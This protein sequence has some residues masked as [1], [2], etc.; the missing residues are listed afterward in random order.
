MVNSISAT[1]YPKRWQNDLTCLALPY[2][3]LVVASIGVI[4]LTIVPAHSK[5]PG[6]AELL[7]DLTGL[8]YG[9]SVTD[10][11]GNVLVA[12][13]DEERFVPASNVKLFVT[14][15]ALAIEQEL[16][17][18]DTGLR[19]V[20]ELTDSGGTNIALV[21]RGDPTIG[22]GA[23][24]QIRC[25]ET[26]AEAVVEAGIT[27]VGDIIGDDQWFADQPRPVGWNWDDLKF[28]HGTS[29]SALSVN[30]NIL[31][32]RV[33]PTNGAGANVRASWLDN[34]SGYFEL[35]NQASTGGADTQKALR[36]ERRI[37]EDVARLYGELP[38]GSR[39]VTLELGVDKPAHLAA[40]YFKRALESKG[41]AVSGDLRARNRPLQYA[42]EPRPLD[43]DEGIA[44]MVCAQGK[45]QAPE[46]AVLAALEP[47]PLRDIV[48]ETNLE[49]KNLYAEV[50][51]R[52]LGR[53]AGTGSSFCGLLKVQAFLEEVGVS[54][55]SYDFDDGSGLS[56]YNRV[57][58]ETVTALLRY[59]AAAPWADAYRDSLPVGGGQTGSLKNR[60]RGT[61]LEGKIFAKTGTLNHADV[62]SGYMIASSGKVLAFSI[63]VNDRPLGSSSARRQIDSTLLKIAEQF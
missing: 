3:L 45:Q 46:G 7:S 2:W 56:N 33:S 4:L 16:S 31:R 34:G 57:T 23:D 53:I 5:E 22:F 13:R 49:S 17:G 55:D 25:L 59:A 61:A 54:R 24:C 43:A 58:P 27:Q 40:W 29:I 63:I 6:N 32:L 1:N 52:Q 21:G 35:N 42:D 10:L 9:V 26:L 18:L 48:N 12:Y 51:L 20:T 41:V 30:D 28:G 36:L 14:A 60:F 15:A 47:A 37:G 8:R 39:S 11:D 19:V 50:L 38:A 44:G 62:L